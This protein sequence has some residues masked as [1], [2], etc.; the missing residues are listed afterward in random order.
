MGKV[1]FVGG[2]YDGKWLN[3][4]N[5]KNIIELPQ[6][7]HFPPT[8]AISIS[9]DIDTI[10]VE[11]ELYRRINFVTKCKTFSFF[12]VE[13]MDSTMFMQALIDRYSMSQTVRG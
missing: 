1:I 8:T 2:S 4:M 12:V 3:V 7:R 13:G 6:R 10:G 5:G 9:V 11:M